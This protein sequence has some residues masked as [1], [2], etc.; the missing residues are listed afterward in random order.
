MKPRDRTRVEAPQRKEP[1]ADKPGY[2]DDLFG[3]HKISSV[4]L[5]IKAACV[6]IEVKRAR[7]AIAR[8]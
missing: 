2:S 7:K 4:A 3:G 1:A 5:S 6:W 8:A